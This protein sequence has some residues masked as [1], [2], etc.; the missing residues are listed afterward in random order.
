MKNEMMIACCHVIA[1]FSF[2]VPAFFGDILFGDLDQSLR[3]A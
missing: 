3:S 2:F 1:L